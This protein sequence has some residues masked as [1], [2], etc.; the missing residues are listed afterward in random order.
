M[1]TY[2]RHCLSLLPQT[3]AEHAQWQQDQKRKAQAKLEAFLLEGIDSEGQEATPDYWQNLRSTVLDQNSIK[4]QIFSQNRRFLL[5]NIVFGS[6]LDQGN[7]SRKF[8]LL[9][10]SPYLCQFLPNLFNQSLC[11]IF[12]HHWL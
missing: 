11:D 9:P 5:I 1:P 8:R 6:C 3:F 2:L 7:G 10:F 4:T 12:H